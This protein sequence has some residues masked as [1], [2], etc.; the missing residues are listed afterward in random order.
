MDW[1]AYASALYMKEKYTGRSVYKT[2][3]FPRLGKSPF[4]GMEAGIVTY[5]A[6]SVTLSNLGGRSTQQEQLHAIGMYPF[7]K[8][9]F[10]KYPNDQGLYLRIM[11]EIGNVNQENPWKALSMQLKIL[12]TS[13][14]P[15]SLKNI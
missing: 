8:Y 5:P 6:G 15:D 12:N 2:E 13:G 10:Q 9:L 14:G 4:N 3:H 11:H 1:Y 7:V